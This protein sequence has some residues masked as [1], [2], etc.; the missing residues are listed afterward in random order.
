[1]SLLSYDIYTENGDCLEFSSDSAAHVARTLNQL[2]SQRVFSAKTLIFSTEF[3]V[4][5]I[6]G[7]SVEYISLRSSSPDEH[8]LNDLEDQLM[9]ITQ[10]EFEKEFGDMAPE[11][12]VAARHANAGETILVFLQLNLLSGR[13]IFLKL[14][15]PKKS[16]PEGKIFFA[17]LFDNPALMFSLK[18]G[19]KGIVNPK[20]IT[21]MIN[22][23][24]PG[25]DVL[26][27]TTIYAD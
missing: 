22:Y 12:R 15:V 11:E 10:E 23:P 17:H 19:G 4:I 18:D 20:K 13:K 24:G 3:S 16:G 2:H 14:Q 27:E 7:E 6:Q 1:M 25:K 21:S 8:G 5:N 9:E 26:P